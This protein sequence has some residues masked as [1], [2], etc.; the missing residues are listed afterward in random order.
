MFS[1]LKVID[2]SA[3]LG[4]REIMWYCAAEDCSTAITVMNNEIRK[5]RMRMAVILFDKEITDSN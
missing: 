3:E 4:V 5:D 1:F 2:I